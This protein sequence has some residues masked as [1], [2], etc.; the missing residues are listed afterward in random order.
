MLY[1]KTDLSLLRF[2]LIWMDLIRSEIFYIVGWFRVALVYIFLASVSM[3]TSW[4]GSLAKWAQM[5]CGQTLI[6]FA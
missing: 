5:T 3:D 2:G 4:E 6:N 1:N